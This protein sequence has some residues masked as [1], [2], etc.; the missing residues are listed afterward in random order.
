MAIWP[1]K[2]KSNT[3]RALISYADVPQDDSAKA[4]KK[5]KHKKSKKDKEA[6]DTVHVSLGSGSGGKDMTDKKAKTITTKGNGKPVTQP[7][8][9]PAPTQH[10]APQTHTSSTPAKKETAAPAPEGLPEVVSLY[11]SLPLEYLPELQKYAGDKKYKDD[12]DYRKSWIKSK[13]DAKGYI[14]LQLPATD[15]YTKIQMYKTGDGSPIMLVETNDCSPTCSNFIRVYRQDSSKW[16]DITDETLPQLDNKYIISKLK[17]AY[18][19]QYDDLDIY[20]TKGYDN[21]DNLKKALVYDI[22]PDLKK[23]VVK[24]QYLP[25]TLY[26]ISWDGKSKFILKKLVE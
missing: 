8:A 21:E 5:D 16:V 17:Q 11:Y 13:N 1:G 2:V 9:K 14:Q 3:A 26:E 15:R 6:S 20:K 7:A 22:S 25:L 18:K 12:A 24:E 19:K 10:P 4:A 23:I